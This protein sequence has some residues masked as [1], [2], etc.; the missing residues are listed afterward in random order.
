MAM[1]NRRVWLVIG[2]MGVIL[3][4]F[5]PVSVWV[6]GVSYDHT[7]RI[8]ALGGALLGSVSGVLGSFAVLR[9]ES[10]MGDAL[11]HAA[12]PG[13]A[14]AFLVGGRDLAGLLLG[15]GIASWL[16]VLFILGVVR[17]TRIKPDTAMAIA[18]ASFFALGL[19]LIEYI[20]TRADAS[21]AGLKKF[22]FGQAA[23]IV[24]EDVMLISAVGTASFL[25]VG[26]FWKEFKLLVFDREFAS[27]NGFPVR[28]LD[29]MLSTLIVVAI[30]LG[31]RLA[32]VIMMVGMLIAPGVAARQWTYSL[33]Q[34]VA[35]AGVFGAFAGIS[36]AVIS[37]T[38]EGMPTGPWII[39]M[40]VAL[41]FVSLNVAPERGL[42]WRWWRQ[43]VD[44]GRFAAQNV[45]RDV[46]V[47]ALHHQDL[48]HPMP[49]GACV[50]ARGKVA[51]I[52]LRTLEKA[53]LVKRIADGWQLTESGIQ[54][55]QQDNSDIPAPESMT[56][57]AALRQGG[58]R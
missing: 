16:S 18:L 43:H 38:G 4:L 36:G 52:G 49:E 19:L 44:R 41:V 21:Q 10:L 58:H 5:I 57:L 1:G 32:G 54:Q 37:G 7:L 50:T 48:T 53:N 40:A 29:L 25:V 45:L 31:L 26:L 13:V 20:Q 17:T 2:A 28:L 6:W 47:H 12:L 51:R 42:L 33:N 15:A 3:F 55:A 24:T 9:Q 35:L 11:S 8:V 27:A 56:R 39:V 34:M 22:I 46:Y 23:A 30:V 14:L